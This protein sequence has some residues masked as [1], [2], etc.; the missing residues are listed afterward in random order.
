MAGGWT[1]GVQSPVKNQVF[2]FSVLYPC[3]LGFGAVN[4][5]RRFS[6]GVERT[7]CEVNF[8]CLVPR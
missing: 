1:S 5:Y 4:G 8:L 6:P 3:H 2:F 7:E